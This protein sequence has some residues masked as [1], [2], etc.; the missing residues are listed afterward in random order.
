MPIAT[1]PWR[2]PPPPL[3]VR[4]LSVPR[5]CHS[6]SCR[7]SIAWLLL[8]CSWHF[9]ADARGNG[10]GGAAS[11]ARGSRF[12]GAAGERILDRLCPPPRFCNCLSLLNRF[13]CCMAQI[14]DAVTLAAQQQA[15]REGTL[16]SPGDAAR[17][18]SVPF[19]PCCCARLLTLRASLV[20]CRLSWPRALC[21]RRW[22]RQHRYFTQRCHNFELEPDIG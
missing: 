12:A 3:P 8:A 6:E 22:R 2:T 10:G 18:G 5:T 15:L 19:P 7:W 13:G 4:P 1:S 20:C 14:R 17:I 11:A 16:V 21:G 9:A